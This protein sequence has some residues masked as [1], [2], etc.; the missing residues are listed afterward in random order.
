MRRRQ[1]RRTPCGCTCLEA[2]F[3]TA[4]AHPISKERTLKTAMG[5]KAGSIAG[6]VTP[7]SIGA[8]ATP[9][10]HMTTHG[11]VG[12]GP[13]D[14]E[15]AA[16]GKWRTG[17]GGCG[18]QDGTAAR[19]TVPSCN[20]RYGSIYGARTAEESSVALSNAGT[21]RSCRYGCTPKWS[22]ED[23]RAV[24]AH[25]QLVTSTFTAISSRQWTGRVVVH[26]TEDYILAGFM[27]EGWPEPPTRIFVIACLDT[28]GSERSTGMLRHWVRAALRYSEMAARGV[29]FTTR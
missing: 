24:S 22:S 19:A 29:C 14:E 26:A 12:V 21:K 3:R 9:V 1:G 13:S 11:A 20:G 15:D 28:Q 2:T 4:S 10:V 16:A 17:D 6:A 18:A 8:S 7:I 25:K 27:A 5:S 23:T